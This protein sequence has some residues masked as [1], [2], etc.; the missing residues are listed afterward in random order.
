MAQVHRA[1]LAKE[2][3]IV[4]VKVQRPD[5][6]PL[7]RADLDILAT[8]AARLNEL[9]TYQ[10][11]DLPGLVEELRFSLTRELDFTREAR[12]MMIFRK[13]L[14]FPDLMYIPEV[15]DA[16][17]TPYVLTMELVEG[18]RLDRLDDSTL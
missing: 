17:S 14:S 4:A 15:F 10:L 1:R 16:Y 18:T 13:T 2:D 5:I 7:I 8:I 11:Y 9:R 3:K 6:R 12:N